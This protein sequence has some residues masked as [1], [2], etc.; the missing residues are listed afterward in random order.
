MAA[1]LALVAG[2]M[3][4]LAAAGRPL[5]HDFAGKAAAVD[6][7][8]TDVVSNMPLVRAFGGSRA[9]ISTSVA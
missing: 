9:T 3:F 7:E 6:G 4:R 2:I 1:G 5:H 8:M